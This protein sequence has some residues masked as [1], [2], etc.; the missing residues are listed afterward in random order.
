MTGSPTLVAFIVA[1][2]AAAGIS[3]LGVAVA[4]QPD[5][6]RRRP[7][8]QLAA[9]QSQVVAAVV[10]AMV[11]LFT[12]RW[13]VGAAASALLVGAWRWL[14]VVSDADM[15]RAKVQAIAKWLEDLRDVVRRSSVGVE[16]ALEMVADNA[17]GVLAGPFDRFVLRRRQGVRVVVALGELADSVEHPTFDAAAAAIVLVVDGAAGGGRLYDTLDELAMAARDEIR[18]REEIDRIRRTYQ[19][20]MRRLVVLTVLFVAGLDAFAGNLVAPY[21]SAAGQ[22]WLIIPCTLWAICL[23]WLRRL[24]HYDLG[25][26]YRLR[27]PDTERA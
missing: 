7:R 19:R 4:P 2:L 10:V 11:V 27:Q 13:L 1:A 12:T 9:H 17:H 15:E 23:I 20:A 6:R 8:S 18:A 16:T 21:R 5:R 3:A 26:R 24:T 22:A 14:F 25:V